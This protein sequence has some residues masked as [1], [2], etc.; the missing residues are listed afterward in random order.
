MGLQRVNPEQLSTGVHT[1]THT[2][3]H[4]FKQ[5][6]DSICNHFLEFQIGLSFSSNITIEHLIDIW[7]RKSQATCS[8][9]TCS[10]PVVAT[11]VTDITSHPLFQ[12]KS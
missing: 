12:G 3:T 2:H 7:S 4:G 8:L 1:R 11:A 9:Q 5:V 6:D 10:S